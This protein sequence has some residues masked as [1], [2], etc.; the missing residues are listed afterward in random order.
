MKILEEIIE[1]ENENTELD[2]KAI[3]YDKIKF[4]NLLKDLISMA[5]AKTEND[6]FII[7]GLKH[8]PNGER[9]FLGINNDFI[10]EASYQQLVHNNI[11][12]E[13][14]F[15]YFPFEFKDKKFG[16]F[17]IF[18]C[19]DPPYMMKK[20]F[21]KLKAGE[22]F[23][24][25]GSH[26]TRILRKDID[27]FIERKISK[28]YFNGEISVYTHQLGNKEFN[29]KH[30]PFKDKPSEKA[31]LEITKLIKEKEIVENSNDK[32]LLF[33]GLNFNHSYIVPTPYEKR[34]LETLKENLEQLDKTY[35]DDDE[36]FIYEESANK[37]NF[38]IFN[39]SEKYIEDASIELK[40]DKKNIFVCNKIISKPVKYNH[41]LDL[42][43]SPTNSFSYE[44]MNY[45]TVKETEKEYIITEIIG[46]LK[47][48]IEQDV[49][50]VPLRILLN[51]DPTEKKAFVQI[52]I[53]GKN[54]KT[55]ITEELILI[56]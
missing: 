45:P 53:F 8:K 43:S 20:D 54:L 11:E 2:F 6:R 41:F 26:Q 46:D 17:K 40:I 33:K 1:F 34:N 5:N 19:I 39:H 32:N 12:P 10:D 37:F 14:N 31:R 47:H 30:I 13:L 28:G 15:D 25:K 29:I 7:V 49:F 4:E 36:Y 27:Y 42:H 35:E 22:S 56:F 18:G 52:K 24:R 21:G 38:K 16:V 51:P 55:P 23:I 48:Q 50:T 3:Q 9:Q 44:N